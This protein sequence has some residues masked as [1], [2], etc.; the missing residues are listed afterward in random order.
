LRKPR[1]R[2]AA[3]TK[4]Q[5]DSVGAQKSNDE[6]E[7]FE[8]LEVD[9]DDLVSDSEDYEINAQDVVDEPFLHE[10][11]DLLD[12]EEFND[13]TKPSGVSRLKS[14]ARVLFRPPPSWT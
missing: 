2:K 8:F 4:A 5:K 9:E 6:P 7:A 13:D 11:I 14:P 1:V 10:A 12:G 3:G